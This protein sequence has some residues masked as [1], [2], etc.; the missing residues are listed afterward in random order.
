MGWYYGD[1]RRNFVCEDDDE[2][3]DAKFPYITKEMMRYYGILFTYKELFKNN[4]IER[5]NQTEKEHNNHDENNYITASSIYRQEIHDN[6]LTNI[7]KNKKSDIEVI[8]ELL[9]LSLIVSDISSSDD[10]C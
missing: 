6:K 10:E 2:I 1:D 3:F 5:I 8:T 9:K 7:S 4:L